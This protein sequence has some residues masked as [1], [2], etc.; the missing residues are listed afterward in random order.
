MAEDVTNFARYMLSNAIKCCEHHRYKIIASDTDSLFIE[1][2]KTKEE[3]EKL[4][5]EL[6]NLFKEILA[7]HNI[8]EEW[9]RI[10]I[11]I[12]RNWQKIFFGEKKKKYAGIDE[13]GKRIIKGFEVR[14]SNECELSRETQDKLIDMILNEEAPAN[15]EQFLSNVK[16]GLLEG[17]FNDKLI[18]ATGFS[19]DAEGYEVDALH[20]RALKMAKDM[21]QLFI[22]G[23]LRYYIRDASG[24]KPEPQLIE[25]TDVINITD[26]GLR[27]YWVH[28]I[29]P[30]QKRIL[31]AVGYDFPLLE[32]KKEKK[33]RRKKEEITLAKWGI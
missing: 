30:P 5:T 1:G 33:V 23:K 15:I 26:E 21:R 11:K 14:R 6:N 4:K 9:R 31:D 16:K 18:F 8:P 29:Y 13:D 24:E 28:R 19:K 25:N 3:A 32:I 12:E 27:Y 7:K 2:L 17:Q 22:D 20:V 10:E